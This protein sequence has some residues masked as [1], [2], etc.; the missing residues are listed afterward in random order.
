MISDQLSEQLHDLKQDVSSD[1]HS[2][3][4]SGSC[5]SQVRT[6]WDWLGITRLLLKHLRISLC[7][8][9]IGPIN[10]CLCLTVTNYQTFP[11]YCGMSGTTWVYVTK[12]AIRINVSLCYSCQVIQGNLYLAGC[13]RWWRNIPVCRGFAASELRDIWCSIMM[14]WDQFIC[15]QVHLKASSK[16]AR[17]RIWEQLKLSNSAHHHLTYILALLLLLCHWDIY[18]Y[19]YIYFIRCSARYKCLLVP[20]SL[21]L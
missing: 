5:S 19:I 20:L 11:N 4:T 21:M 17:A 12:K 7:T 18:I 14:S 15:L 8:T 2:I 10:Q 13:T 6:K 16:R 1:V 3:K 9:G